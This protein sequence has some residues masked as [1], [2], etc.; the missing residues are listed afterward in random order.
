LKRGGFAYAALAVFYCF[1]VFP[2]VA[3]IASGRLQESNPLNRQLLLSEGPAT[4]IAFRLATLVLVTVLVAASLSLT[5]I[6]LSRGPFE[7]KIPI[8]RLEELV[9]GS[10]TLFYAFAIFHNLTA[11]APVA[12]TLP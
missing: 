9:V 2:T 8:D 10:I 3:L 6:V 12:G 1:D 4:W 11:L 7:R 5:A